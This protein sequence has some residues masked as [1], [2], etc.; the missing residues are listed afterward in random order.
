MSEVL[1]TGIGGFVGPYV[2][3]E[4]SGHDWRVS[5]T[6]L[7]QAPQLTGLAQLLQADLRDRRALVRALEALRP[8]AIV[9]LAAI[10]DVALAFKAPDLVRE[11]N[12]SGTHNLLQAVREVCGECRVLLAGSAYEY[13]LPQCLPIT[14]EHPLRPD[15]PYAASK[16]E[17]EEMA[18]EFADELDIIFARSFNH[19]G[20]GQTESFALSSFAAQIARI[21]RGQQAPVISVGNLEARRDFLDVRDVARAYRLLLE[22]GERGAAYNVCSGT[23]YRIKDLLDELISLASCQIEVRTDEDRLRPSDLPVMQGSHEKLTN[24]TGWSPMIDMHETL[25][26]LLDYW[27]QAA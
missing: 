20:A 9:H 15:N 25:R 1:V 13:G 11:V 3:D 23:A 16:V 4:L 14:E 10:S 22:R 24:H 8:S 17:A 26:G 5:G 12:V 6:Y 2:L 21:E 7:K 18:R 19:T 27:R